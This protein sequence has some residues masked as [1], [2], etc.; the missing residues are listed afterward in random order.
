M[1]ACRLLMPSRSEDALTFAIPSFPHLAVCMGPLLSGLAHQNRAPKVSASQ[2]LIRMARRAGPPHQ[3]CEPKGVCVANSLF[4]RAHQNRAPKVS[5]SQHLIRMARRAGP[6]HQNCEPKGVC[7]ANSLS[8]GRVAPGCRF[9]TARPRCLRCSTS[10]SWRVAPRH[11][12]RTASLKEFASQTAS[13]FMVC[14]T[15]FPAMRARS[16]GHR[17]VPQ[18]H[19]TCVA[20]LYRRQGASPRAAAFYYEHM[21]FASQTCHFSWRAVPSPSRRDGYHGAH[22]AVFFLS[23]IRSR[24]YSSVCWKHIC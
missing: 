19:S 23:I 4:F 18:A 21:V 13:I 20:G 1:S 9:R 3:N 24:W 22:C 12:I 15:R 5:A 7:V 8:S 11:P 6:P 17:I 16:A 10:S 2:H 14:R